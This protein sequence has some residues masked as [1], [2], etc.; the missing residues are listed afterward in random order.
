MTGTFID[1]AL[2]LADARTAVEAAGMGFRKVT[3]NAADRDFVI[4]NMP[5]LDL[6]WKRATPDA[7]GGQNYYADMTLEAEINAFDL[8]S[9]DD[10][11]TIRDNLT[12]LLQRF[13]Q[14]NPHFSS[15]SDT[16]IVGNV[17]FGTGED[18]NTG[19]FVAIAVLDFHVKLYANS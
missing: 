1:Y 3:K 5:L 10:A 4:Q 11:A 8:S 18:K 7:V 15:A 12:G 9:V 2:I 6:R 14:Q 19:A 17:E 13:F 16:V